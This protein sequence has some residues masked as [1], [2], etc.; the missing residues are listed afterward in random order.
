LVVITGTIFACIWIRTADIKKRI[1]HNLTIGDGR[2]QEY[3]GRKGP[4]E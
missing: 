1:K 4:E 3:G 2:E